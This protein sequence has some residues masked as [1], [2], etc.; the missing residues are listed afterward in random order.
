ML[1][2]AQDALKTIRA[3]HVNEIRHLHNPPSLIRKVLQSICVMME[4]PPERV[5]RK[6]KPGE[7]ED[8]WWL[9]SQ[10]MMNDRDF[11]K[12]LLEYDTDNIPEKV[13]KKIRDKFVPDPEFVPTRVAQAG[14]AAKGLC[15][16][17][18]ALDQYERINKIVKPKRMRA[19][20]AE[21]KYQDTVLRLQA[22]Q[23]ELRSI[24]ETF[25]GL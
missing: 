16:W 2:K 1:K 7:Y 18:L 8:D 15:Q 10:K 25:E 20:E 5:L 11:L 24:M 21:G 13:M 6:D 22:K 14:F 4:F 23:A 3:E 17:V 19:A 9:A 12:N